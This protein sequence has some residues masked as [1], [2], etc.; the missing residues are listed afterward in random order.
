MTTI[1]EIINEFNKEFPKCGCEDAHDHFHDD[2]S[3]S[4]IKSFLRSK[5]EQ[6]AKEM[7]GEKIAQDHFG[8]EGNLDENCPS[9][10]SI[11]A[12]NSAI[13]EAQSL[14]EQIIK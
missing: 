13:T 14:Y 4:A 5:I 7:I 10:R 3:V 8:L 6:V 12:Y 9:C 1:T 11:E 2:T